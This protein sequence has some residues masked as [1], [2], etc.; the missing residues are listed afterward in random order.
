MVYFV[1]RCLNNPIQNISGMKLSIFQKMESINKFIA[2]SAV[3]IF[4][5]TVLGMDNL[6]GLVFLI[7]FFLGLWLL[8]S[9]Y[10]NI[11]PLLKEEK[12]FFFSLSIVMGTVV[13]TTLVNNTDLARADRFLAPI[14]AIPVYLHFKRFLLDEKYLWIGLVL[15]ALIAAS[16][17]I[18][19][20]FWLTTFP[21][22]TGVVNPILFGDLALL[23]G[24]MSLAGMG[25]F[26]AQKQWMV[27]IPAL[28]MVAGLL[29]S[30]LSLVRGAWLALPFLV[31]LLAWYASNRLKLKVTLL[32]LS[33]ILLTVGSLFFIPQ[34]GVQKRISASVENLVNYLNSQNVNDKDRGTSVGVRF[35]M[36]KAA[37]IIFMDNPVVGGGWGDYMA[38]TRVLADLG[39]VNKNTAIFYHPHNQFISALA[40]GGLLGFLAI[41]ILFIFPAIIFYRSIGNYSAAETQRLALAG[42]MLIV[43]FVGFSLTESILERSRSIIFF[44]F[45]LA[46]L[47]ALFQASRNKKC[48]DIVPNDGEGDE[49]KRENGFSASNEGLSVETCKKLD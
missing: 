5:A 11:F 3:I 41:S 39:L 29:A 2:A 47:M 14:M 10:K 20:V 43:G 49:I 24:V 4:P 45:Y 28:A 9:D 1:G 40:K 30:G 34:T 48:R 16:I 18:Y 44:S 42:L 15:G 31:L 23:M 13:V 32:G 22:A 19:Q 21:R 38:K 17:A 37:G 7:V 26:K 12:Y 46:A 25:W 36:W 27:I 35:E 33:L 6:H 8:V